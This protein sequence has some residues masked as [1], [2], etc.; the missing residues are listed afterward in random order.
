MKLNICFR[1]IVST[2]GDKYLCY[3]LNKIMFTDSKFRSKNTFSGHIYLILLDVIT[4]ANKERK[5]FIHIIIKEK[6]T[7]K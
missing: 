6:A 1:R 5:Y 7:W 4:K 3:H 2:T